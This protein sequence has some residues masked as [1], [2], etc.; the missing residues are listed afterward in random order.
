MSPLVSIVIPVFN[1]NEAHFRNCIESAL[2]Q[3]YQNIEIIISENHSTNGASDVIAKYQ[4]DKIRKVT[5]ATFLDMKDNFAFAASCV[6]PSSKYLSFLSS[7]DLL[8]PDAIAE[9]VEL[10][11][12]NQSIAFVAGNIIQS[13]E[14]PV[15]F[16]QI[17]NR[18][19][20]P[21]NVRGLHTFPQTIALFCP[22][23]VSSTW[24]AGDLIRHDAYKATGGFAACDYYLLG[25]LWLTKE[26]IKQK[27]GD[28]GLL[29]ATTAF[30]RQR[31]EGVL[32]ADGERGLSVYLDM[33]RYNNE[34][35][36]I[37]RNRDIGFRQRYQ[38]H[39]SSFLVLLK[40]LALVL[41]A[42]KFH[43]P[44]SEMHEKNF[45]QYIQATS[46]PVEKYLMGRAVS[47][48]GIPLYLSALL[49]RFI[50]DS[51]RKVLSRVRSGALR[52]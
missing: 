47:V 40:I 20:S 10:A 17:E 6:T 37:V 41:V 16:F 35:L 43:G 51:V 1:Q 8:A 52:V 19:R 11:E 42:R 15:D 25:D 29:G 23:R 12:N 38:M 50:V 31:V 28:F 27:N 4:S 33:L 2:C 5:P 7:D 9:L 49:A 21:E 30:F 46:R 32:P 48:N 26:L 24:M 18:I 36:E 45:R 14:P 3:S 22:W 44:L 34:M 13:I 39:W